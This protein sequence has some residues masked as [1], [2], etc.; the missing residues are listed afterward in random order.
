MVKSYKPILLDLNQALKAVDSRKE[1][2]GF[3]SVLYG[4]EGRF[5]PSEN[6]A[7][8]KRYICKLY[9]AGGY[10]KS[11]NHLTDEEKILYFEPA[12]LIHNPQFVLLLEEWNRNDL[13]FAIKNR[14]RITGSLK[15]IISIK[16]KRRLLEVFKLLHPAELRQQAQYK[17]S[18]LGAQSA[19]K[20]KEIIHQEVIER[21]KARAKSLLAKHDKREIASIIANEEGVTSRTIRDRLKK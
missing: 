16:N 9:K 19:K 8:N 5:I 4:V 7:L 6:K 12:K 17:K 20:S 15:K 3:Q 21:T 14:Q 2:E 18:A 10:L 13:A 11:I 1:I